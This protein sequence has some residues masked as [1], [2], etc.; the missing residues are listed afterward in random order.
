MATRQEGSRRDG[1]KRWQERPHELWPA[2]H[3]EVWQEI[4]EGGYRVSTL[5][6]VYRP[7]APLITLSDD[8]SQT[9]LGHRTP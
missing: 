9:F 4:D 2:R 1:Q 6:S 7:S 5:T 8:Y 3:Q